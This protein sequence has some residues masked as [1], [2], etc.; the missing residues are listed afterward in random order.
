MEAVLTLLSPRWD[1]EG[2]LM[3]GTQPEETRRC[4][5]CQAEA[6]DKVISAH[7]QPRECEGKLLLW[8]LDAGIQSLEQQE[9]QE[10]GYLYGIIAREIFSASHL[11]IFSDQRKLLSPL[12]LIMFPSNLLD[13][14]CNPN[15]C[16]RIFIPVI[17]TM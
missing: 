13:I 9:A 11:T 3:R 12:F 16:K 5:P 2:L 7:I 15:L 1:P 8:S 6:A 4:K 10:F 17:Q 14:F